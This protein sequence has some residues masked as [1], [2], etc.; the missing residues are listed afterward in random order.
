MFGSCAN[1]IAVRESDVDIAVENGVVAW[2]E[3][4]GNGGEGEIIGNVLEKI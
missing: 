4:W 2:G 3:E 1:G